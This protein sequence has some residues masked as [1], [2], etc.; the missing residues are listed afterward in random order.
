M[1]C[2]TRSASIEVITIEDE[3]AVE[4]QEKQDTMNE[5]NGE[6]ADSESSHSF[7]ERG[8]SNGNRR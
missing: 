4:E 5:V 8:L 1:P 2:T 3:M 7:N 6:I